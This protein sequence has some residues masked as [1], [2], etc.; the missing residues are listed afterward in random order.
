MPEPVT[1]IIIL[2]I[3]VITS[4]AGVLYWTKILQWG[5]TSLLPWVQQNMPSLEPYVREAFI[6]IDKVAAPTYALVRDAWQRV[7]ETLVEQVEVFECQADGKWTV[8]VISKVREAL[9]HLGPAEE[10]EISYTTTRRVAYA[11]L[12][13]AVR[14][15]WLREGESRYQLD[16]TK[17]RD[18]E[19]GLQL[20]V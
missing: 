5:M 19:L 2:G 9:E 12:P 11:D 13:S 18:A 4:A 10:E 20:S 17:E 6:N 3:T 15:H 8:T 14:E 16:V 7:R 1:I